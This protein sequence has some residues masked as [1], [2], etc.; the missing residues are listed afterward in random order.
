MV[1]VSTRTA[2]D[3]REDL[4][5]AEADLE[6]LED[7]SLHW[8]QYNPELRNGGLQDLAITD[9]L[10]HIKELRRELDYVTNG[11]TA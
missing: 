11:E 2:D 4:E 8:E 1:Q 9:C 6:G 3:I 5:Q 7:G 10:E